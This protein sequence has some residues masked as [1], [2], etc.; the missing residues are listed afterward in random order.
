MNANGP[1][2]KEYDSNGIL[3]NPITKENPYLF[4]PHVGFEKMR[5]MAVGSKQR[6]WEP[7]WN[8]FFKGMS[9]VKV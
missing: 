6:V 7:I 1:Y 2:V 3:L 4:R 8:K 9:P 5:A